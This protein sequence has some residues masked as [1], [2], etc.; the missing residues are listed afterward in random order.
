MFFT[1]ELLASY[2]K[3]PINNYNLSDSLSENVY[4]FVS[5]CLLL[6]KLVYSFVSVCLLLRKNVYS[7]VSVCLLFT[8]SRQGNP[9]CEQKSAKGQH[10]ASEI[11]SCYLKI[12]LIEYLYK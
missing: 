3:N 1:M 10:L 9:K 8:V 12:A 4:S 11:N 6:R 5:V 2:P 7:F